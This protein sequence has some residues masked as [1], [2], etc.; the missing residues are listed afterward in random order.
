MLG[1][2]NNIKDRPVYTPDTD[3]IFLVTDTLEDKSLYHTPIINKGATVVS[4][5]QR[6]DRDSIYFNNSF[7]M[8][9][10][11]PSPVAQMLGNND[12]TIEFWAY[13]ST[14][15]SGGNRG[16]VFI[17]RTINSVMDVFF[18]GYSTERSM[19]SS[20]DGSNWN[21]LN[22]AACYSS[23]VVNQWTHYAFV[24]QR[25]SLKTYMNGILQNSY[26]ISSFPNPISGYFGFGAQSES[27]TT[28]NIMNMQDMRFSK[29]ARYTANFTPPVRFI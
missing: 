13:V 21:V 16:L 22:G 5:N 28:T 29:I 11:M 9:E 6:D 3:T 27:T 17:Q 25:P 15:S 8:A 4:W 20:S 26:S 24:Y 10:T 14:W 1:V 2:T 23:N 12:W 18:G 19:Y 7:F